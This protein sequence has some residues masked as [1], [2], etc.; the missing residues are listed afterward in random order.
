MIGTPDLGWHC[1]GD[2]GTKG[3]IMGTPDLKRHCDVDNLLKG[4]L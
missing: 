3:V 1:D 2:T 4:V